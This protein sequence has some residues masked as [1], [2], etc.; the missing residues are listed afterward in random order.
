M[1]ILREVCT[2][3]VTTCIVA[4]DVKLYIM[5]S[6]SLN[7]SPVCEPGYVTVGRHNSE[8]S[9]AKVS[10]DRWLAGPF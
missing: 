2:T 4:G 10:W 1:V 5:K 3:V 7:V 6:N 9:S 8:S